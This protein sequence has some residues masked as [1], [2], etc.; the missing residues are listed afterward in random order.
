MEGVTRMLNPG[1]TNPDGQ[2]Y[3]GGVPPGQEHVVLQRVPKRG[4]Q[5]G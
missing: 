1:R 3:G 4:G 5:V 2:C